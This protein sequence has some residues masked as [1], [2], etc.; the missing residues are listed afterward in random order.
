[1]KKIIFDKII[2]YLERN[3]I[4]IFWSIVN[5]LVTFFILGAKWHSFILCLI[6]YVISISVALSPLGEQILRLINGVR[7]LYT[8]R[9]KDYLIPLFEE[10]YE[11]VKQ[12]YPNLPDMEI[13]IIDSLTVNACAMGR[14]TIA[15]T[16]GAVETFTEDELKGVLLHEMGH[17]VNGDTKAILLNMIG[18]GLFSIGV[19]IVKTALLILDLVLLPF[20]KRTGGITVLIL[21]IIHFIFDVLLI[22]FTLTGNII[23]SINSRENEYRADCFAFE[24]GYGEDLISALYLLQKMSLGEDMALIQKMQASHPHIAKRIGALE[25][26][27]DKEVSNT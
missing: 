27:E 4:Y 12:E 13:C 6:V 24:N 8:R 1:M 2:G 26:L 15:V 17:I 16:R 21:S 9:E 14:H 20:F 22:G 7:K 5:F 19:I 10:I 25:Y 11:D 23:L 3:Y 18:N